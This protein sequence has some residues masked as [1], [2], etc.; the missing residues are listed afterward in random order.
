ME[1]NCVWLF[2]YFNFESSYDVL[3]SK[4][5]CILLNKNINFHKNEA[6]SK[7]EN[8]HTLLERRTKLKVK[9]WWVGVRKRKTRTFFVPFIFSEGKFFKIC[10]LSQCIAYWI[11]FQNIHPFTYQKT[12][13]HT[14]LLLVSKFVESLQ[15]FLHYVQKEIFPN[16]TENI[17]LKSYCPKPHL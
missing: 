11:H 13:L 15:C 16:V 10:V 1:Q 4:S 7:I 9:L 17:C 5:P 12:L 8:P 2:Y 6:E 3:K 14:L